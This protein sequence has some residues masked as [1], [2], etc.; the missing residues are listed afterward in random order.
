MSF[1]QDQAATYGLSNEN[2]LVQYLERKTRAATRGSKARRSLGNLY[3][4][5]VIAEDYLADRQS[6]FTDLLARMRDLPFGSKLQN[7]PLDNRLND[8]FARQYG[9]SGDLLPVV[10]A[11]VDGQ[12]ARTISETLLSNGE[13]DPR[14]VAEFIVAAID[15]YVGLITEKQ[16]SVL[17]ELEQ[18][19]T[20]DALREFFSESFAQNADARLFEVASYALLAEFYRDKAVFVGDTRETISQRPLQLFKTGRT[21]A[22]DGGIDFV[23]RPLGRFFQVTETLDFTKYF[24]DFEKVNRFPVSFVIKVDQPAEKVVARIA[25]SAKRSGKY[26]RGLVDTYMSLFEEVF[27]LVDLRRIADE[28]PEDSVNRIKEELRLQFQLEYGLLD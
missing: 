11:T 8:E 14:T 2:L 10:A 27:T 26:E 25:D 23:L 20:L 15:E 22:N 7:H 19:E 28:L 13:N 16:T 24:L 3:A 17:D 5:Y 9:V 18:I 21:N 12:K 6:R 4:L 1:I